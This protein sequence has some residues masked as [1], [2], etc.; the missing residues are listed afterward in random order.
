[1]RI[2]RMTFQLASDKLEGG[3]R[4]HPSLCR[5]PEVFLRHHPFVDFVIRE[6]HLWLAGVPTVLLSVLQ[7]G[8]VYDV[9]VRFRVREFEN[10]I[11]EF[12]GQIEEAEWTGEVGAWGQTILCLRIDRQCFCGRK[13]ESECG[14]KAIGLAELRIQGRDECGFLER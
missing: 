1:V 8:L 7:R 11:L 10:R 13:C 3:L 6:A 14:S 4:F 9:E 5:S 12:L 2:A